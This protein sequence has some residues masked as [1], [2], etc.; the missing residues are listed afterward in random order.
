[1]ISLAVALPSGTSFGA[2]DKTVR[3]ERQKAQKLRQ[4]Q[5]NDR[6]SEIRDASNSFREFARD[7][8]MEYRE[9][10]RDLDT[11]FRL[12]QVDM[13]AERDAKIAETEVELRQ[14]ISQLM[15][16][17]NQSSD[18]AAVEQLK[19]D[20]KTY[21]D[22][23]FEIQ[24]QAAMEKHRE[25]IDNELKKHQLL[26]ERD[27]AALAMASDLGLR[28]QYE[29]ILATP[30]GD[31]LTKQEK[32]WN[33]REKKEVVKL[34]KSN[35]RLLGEFLYGKELRQWEIEK[36]R[37]DFNLKWQKKSELQAL[38][39]E[40]TFYSSALMQSSQGADFDQAAFNKRMTELQKQNQLINIKY[41][42]IH[43]KNRI[44][45]SEERRKM[46]TIK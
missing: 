44:I 11:E 33:E 20:M 10:A 5:K 21:S 35:Q 1:M 23:I 13:N 42:K 29:P 15:L 43:D 41:K 46:V 45:R 4:Q 26:S 37:E 3:A 22:Q 16:N 38:N 12:Q 32:S 18:E 36:K 31:G 17:P 7:L 39:L 24:K 14:K 40:Q 2:D 8:K 25:Y 19:A 27:E 9:K 28:S 34:F 6:N 30:I